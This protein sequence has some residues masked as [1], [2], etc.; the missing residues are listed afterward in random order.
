MKMLMMILGLLI[1][2][3]TAGSSD[4]YDEC[5]AAADCVAGEPMSLVQMTLQSLLGLA[6]FA[7]GCL[8]LRKEGYN[9]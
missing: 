1:M 5:L 8:G 7:L 6:L 3:G 2:A 9:D 4:Y